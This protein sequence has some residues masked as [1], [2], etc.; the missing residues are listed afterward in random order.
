MTRWK[1]FK[2]SHVW[3]PSAF[4][5]FFAVVFLANGIMIFSALNT[6]R[7]LASESPWVKDAGYK[8]VVDPD[9]ARGGLDWRVGIDVTGHD[10]G[11][12]A[13]VAVRL[14]G[15]SGKPVEANRVRV[16]FVRPTDDGYDTTARLQPQGGGV[17]RARVDLPVPGLWEVRV[18]AERGSDSIHRSK[19]V[20]LQP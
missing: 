11:R 1:W 15:G 17:Y 19:R 16:G 6:W 8:G 5:A 4:V 2:Q 12:R 14:T 10:G 20:T 9:A 13:E 18:A 7:G 3:I